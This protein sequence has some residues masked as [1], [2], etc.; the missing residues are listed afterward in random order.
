MAQIKAT[1]MGKQ[2]VDARRE[3]IVDEAI[4]GDVMNATNPLI[5]SI[6]QAFPSVGKAIRKNPALLD[7]ALSKL[8][9]RGAAVAPAAS[10][11]GHSQAQTQFNL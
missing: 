5:G 3:G 11:N 8:A 9:N 4:A 7:F 1:F 10:N 6:L 2:S